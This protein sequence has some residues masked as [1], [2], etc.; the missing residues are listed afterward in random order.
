MLVTNFFLILGHPSCD[1]SDLL[2]DIHHTP[3]GKW[4]E[5]NWASHKFFEFLFLSEVSFKMVEH[6]R[7]R[8]RLPYLFNAIF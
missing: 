5:E 7:K 2:D 4:F 6:Q 8:C 3:Y 1:S